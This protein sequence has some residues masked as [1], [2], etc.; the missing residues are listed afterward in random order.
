MAGNFKPATK[1]FT[2]RGRL[3]KQEQF[4]NE[5]RNKGKKHIGAKEHPQMDLSSSINAGQRVMRYPICCFRS[6]T[7]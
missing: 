4:Q 2:S 6:K 5:Y 1:F 3:E 7:V